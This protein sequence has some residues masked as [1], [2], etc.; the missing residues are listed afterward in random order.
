M[1][2]VSSSLVSIIMPIYNADKYLKNSIQSILNQ[3]YSNWELLIIDDG[4]TDNT[5]EILT[6]YHDPRIKVYFN[7]RNIGPFPSRN[8][9]L[10]LA[11][12]DFI[13]FQDADDL[14]HPN[15]LK[16]QL[17]TFEED[18][19]LGIVGTSIEIISERGD[20]INEI[21]YP[22]ED[23]EIKKTNQTRNAFFNPTA[24][25]K[26][27]VYENIGGFREYLNKYSNQ[28]YDWNYLILDCYKS[29]NIP[30][31][32]YKYRQVNNSV[33]KKINPNRIIGDKIV[34]FLGKRRRENNGLDYI[35]TNEVSIVD[36][37]ANEL[38]EPFKKDISLIYREYASRYMYA[39]LRKE[40]IKASWKASMVEPN[41]LVNWRTLFYC[42]RKSIL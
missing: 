29:K 32:L 34:Q 4:S 21:Y 36:K 35:H 7:E 5:K 28:D 19:E 31:L 40:A 24:M 1:Y 26:R 17:N 11:K 8:K 15:R 2:S 16:E 39:G 6:S 38:L 30:K 42:I 33:S 23:W 22:I 12:G 10:E 37:Y 9:L 18:K 25:I 13:T 27:E 41:K 3:T 14:S 20:K